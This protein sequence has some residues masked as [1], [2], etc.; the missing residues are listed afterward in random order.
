M[1]TEFQLLAA[2]AGHHQFVALARYQ[3]RNGIAVYHY[4]K[5]RVSHSTG[6]YSIEIVSLH[7]DDEA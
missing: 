4:D 7:L 5:R 2:V 6:D 1:K 3:T